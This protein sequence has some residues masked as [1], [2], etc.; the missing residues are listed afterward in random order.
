METKARTQLSLEVADSDL[1]G[2]EQAP[3]V[4]PDSYPEN[5]KQYDHWMVGV[6]NAEGKKQAR[7]IGNETEKPFSWSDPDNWTTFEKARFSAGD[8]LL[9]GEFV[10]FVL[11]RDDDKPYTDDPDPCAYIDF[12]DAR[13]PATGNIHPWALDVVRMARSYAS[14]STSG[15][16]VH[17]EVIGELPDDVTQIGGE[18]KPLPAHEDFPEASI[19]I[20]D[21]K[22]IDIMSGKRIAG[23]PTTATRQDDLLAA[24]CDFFLEDHERTENAGSYSIDDFTYPPEEIKTM[25]LGDMDA[26]KDAI[27]QVTPTDIDLR[28]T[29]TEEQG[30]RHSWDPCWYNSDSGTT[31]GYDAGEHIWI[32]R[33][34]DKKLNALDVVALEEG[35]IHS[36]GEAVTGKDFHDALKELRSRGAHIPKLEPPEYEDDFDLDVDPE[37]FQRETTGS[38]A[39]FSAAMKAVTPDDIVLSEETASEVRRAGERHWYHEPS[40]EIVDTLQLVAHAEGLTERV[41]DRTSG[42]VQWIQL[43]HALRWRGADVPQYEP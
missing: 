2:I 41:S 39:V 13:D 29:K 6:I 36:V 10:V 33:N 12:D 40:G 8:M 27:E 14:V 16:G 17:I 19:E 11:D 5:W 7:A 30:D 15:S 35:H 26:I 38:L 3:N 20:Y 31:L 18:G 25:E 43:G 32:W 1:L 42:R 22:R 23:T 34:G 28:S 4:F 24:L 9:P 37:A 21:G